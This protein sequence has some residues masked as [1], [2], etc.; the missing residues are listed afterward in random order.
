[1]H[2][3]VNHGLWI[4][5]GLLLFV[6]ALIRFSR[7]PTNRTGTTFLLFYTGVLFYYALLI[8]LWLLVIIL[9]SAGGYGIDGIPIAQSLKANEWLSPSLPV[10]GFLLITVASQFKFVSK[11]DTAARQFCI[12]LAAIPA[13]AEQLAVEL[14]HGQLLLSDRPLIETVSR[15]I[16]KNIGA[17]A[18]LFA[19][20]GALE[21]R[22]TRAVS[23]YWLFIMPDNAGIPLPFPTNVSGRSTYTRIMRLNEKAVEQSIALYDSLMENALACFTSSKP[24]R[25]MEEALKKNIQDLSLTICRLIARWVLYLEVTENQRRKRLSNMGLNPRDHSPAFGR[26]QWVASILVIIVLF[27]F[28]SIAIPG[29][30]P[31][32]QTFM[33]SVLM[34]IQLGMAVIAGTAVAQ[35]FIRRQE[36][37]VWKFPPLAELTISALVV[38]G[39]CIVLRIGWPL[40]PDLLNT[41]SI[42][43]TQSLTEFADRWPF[44]LLP[45][46]CTF[47][48]GLMCAHLGTRTWGWIRFALLGG[49]LN[50]GTFAIAT[51]LI[52]QLLSVE[53]LQKIQG[54]SPGIIKLLVPLSVAGFVLGAIVLAIFP[55]SIRSNKLPTI[56][57]PLRPLS[58]G[59]DAGSAACGD[60]SNDT[61][62]EA[63]ER[64]GP[65][66]ASKELGAYNRNSVDELQGRYVCF[67]PTFSNSAVV[68]AY[69]VSIHWDDKRAS[70]VFEERNR[71]DS[72]HSQVGQ[73]YIPDGKPFMSLVT[74]DKGAV[75]II[76]VTR[77]DHDGVARGLILTLS[78]P[79]GTHF[80]PASAPVVLRRLSET[81]PQMG[82]VHQDSEDYPTYVRQLSEVE[83]EFATFASLSLGLKVVH[84]SAA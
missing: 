71:P 31:F 41:G 13:E 73:G 14:A 54:N 63:S 64:I 11:M 32:S 78:N 51:I 69:E 33:Y 39:L 67:R 48:I 40:V 22:F 17:N 84:N 53:F 76:M 2:T 23:L 79:G 36:E 59:A 15:E 82:F 80:I 66:A 61:I 58:I 57:A 50:A 20:D 70:L 28:M 81:I 7:P 19:N 18:L 74:A 52:T 10:V 62:S 43:L 65:R 5:S 24:T 44:V 60:Q 12:Q 75:R 68:N 77:P 56:F 3:V 49:L 6:V 8:G 4:V 34:A 21:S 83:P 35:R 27:L 42:S 1:M 46:L 38:V 55:R 9:V 30:Q 26:D 72:S 45:F 29:Q 25:A 16:T 37:N 47:S